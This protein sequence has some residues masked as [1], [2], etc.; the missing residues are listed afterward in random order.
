VDIDPAE[1]RKMEMKIE[2]PVVADAGEFIRELGRRIDPGDAIDRPRW[3]E[4][5]RRWRVQYP[6]VLPKYWAETGHVNDYV[7]ID[8]LSELLT[9]DDMLI[10]GSSGACSERTMQAVRVK[11]GLRVFN[12]EGLGPMGFGIPAAIG[13]CIASGGRRTVCIDGDGGFAMNLQE[14][15]VVRRLA[16]PIKF[17]VLNNGGYG[18]IQ[19]TQQT[20]FGGHFVAS[21]RSSGLTL[22]NIAAVANAFDIPAMTI[23]NHAGIREQVR[24]ALATDGPLVCEVMVSPEQPTAPRIVSRQKADGSMESAP[25]EDLWPFLGRE[26]FQSNMAISQSDAPCPW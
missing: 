12:S 24:A 26:E 20:Y 14:L 2:I 1:I 15:E 16:L 8:V 9:A 4:R 5:C 6:V 25:M 13:A 11:A 10:P 7:L 3:L 19:A 17:F 23:A 22:P 18:S 21:T